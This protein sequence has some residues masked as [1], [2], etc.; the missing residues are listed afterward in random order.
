VVA[1]AAG[2]FAA[3]ADAVMRAAAARGPAWRAAALG[4]RECAAQGFRRLEGAPAG[5]S[6][7]CGGA[8]R[9]DAATC[10]LAADV[11]HRCLVT[12]AGGGNQNSRESSPLWPVCNF[13]GVARGIQ[14][15]ALS[16]IQ[17][18]YA[19][20]ATAFYLKEIVC[21]ALL[22]WNRPL[23]SARLQTLI[24]SFLGSNTAHVGR[25]KLSCRHIFMRGAPVL[26]SRPPRRGL[27]P[28]GHI[29]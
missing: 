26:R 21:L 4:R 9:E 1:S 12:S 28:L 7:R 22:K 2:G 3:A 24:F 6:R 29:F 13:A 5:Q 10:S 16:L 8:G 17:P 19:K 15:A 11:I 14:T 23:Y 20:Y 18:N 27:S 25:P